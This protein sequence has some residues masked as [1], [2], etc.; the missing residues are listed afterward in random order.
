LSPPSSPCEPLDRV[1]TGPPEEPDPPACPGLVRVVTGCEPGLVVPP[2]VPDP[3]WPGLVRVLTGWEAGAVPA[4]VAE[5]VPAWPGLVRVL[6]GLPAEPVLPALAPELE[7][8]WPGL[9][10]VAT[11]DPDDTRAG[12]WC[13]PL[14]RVRAP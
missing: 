3:A 11:P 12:P 8:A 14:T 13:E 7:P 1:V 5:P 6:T 9:V 2:L 4:P 10:R